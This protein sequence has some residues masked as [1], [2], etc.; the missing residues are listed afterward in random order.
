MYW[1]LRDIADDGEARKKA[2]VPPC[3]SVETLFSYDRVI[4]MVPSL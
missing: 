3:E 4:H 2:V 1:I